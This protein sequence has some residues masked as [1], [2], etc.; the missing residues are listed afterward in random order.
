MLS[1][2]FVLYEKI[3]KTEKSFCF[4]CFIRQ[5]KMGKFI[6]DKKPL[7]LANERDDFLAKTKLNNRAHDEFEKNSF[8]KNISSPRSD[9][10]D[11]QGGYT[12]A[13]LKKPLNIDHDN[14]NLAKSNMMSNTFDS[15]KNSPRT[16][17]SL[18]ENK[19]SFEK[20]KRTKDQELFNVDRGNKLLWHN[21]G[22]KFIYFFNLVDHSQLMKQT[23]NLNK[24]KN[25]ETKAS[26]RTFK[27]DSVLDKRVINSEE[28]NDDLDKSELDKKLLI[29]DLLSVDGKFRST[30]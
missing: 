16:L 17:S 11:V 27:T 23:R 15:R 14:L 20:L 25:E 22:H 24:N 2:L 7:P 9:K 18:A 28:S 8:L 13:K 21:F 10:S 29:I 6:R 19:E 4:Y 26:P 1:K 5:K 30:I 12:L 3:E